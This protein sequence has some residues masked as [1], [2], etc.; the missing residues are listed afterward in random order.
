MDAVRLFAFCRQHDDWRRFRFPQFFTDLH[1]VHL[2]HHQVEENDI[3][4]CLKRHFKRRLSI[5][6]FLDREIFPLQ[7][8]LQQAT[9][10]FFIVD[11]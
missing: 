9:N 8:H 2:R 6:C 1:P 11:D 5:V 3:V 7:I 10:P 4:F